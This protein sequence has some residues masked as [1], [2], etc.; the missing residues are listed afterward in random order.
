MTQSVRRAWIRDLFAVLLLGG[1]CLLFF[2]AIITP[3]VAD[4]GSFPPGD[5][6][7]QFH[8]FAVFEAHELL[9]GHIPLW[10]P[11][12]YS[13]HPFE[14]DIQAAI[15]YPVSLLTILL[16]W[17]VSVRDLSFLA[18][19]WEAILHFWL[20]AV[21]TYFFARRLLHH[22]GA[23]L[24]SAIVFAFGGYLTS[25]PSQ[26]LAVLETATWLPLVLWL[27]D[28]GMGRLG[29]AHESSAPNR[30]FA[31]RDLWPMV[32]AGLAWGFALLAGHP[33]TAMYIFYTILLYM[34]FSAWYYHV[35][36][37]RAL[38]GFV[39]LQVL[40][41]ALAAVQLIPGLE[42]MRLSVRA[43]IGYDEV[44]GGFARQDILQ[45]LLPGSSGV[46]SPLYVGV[47]PLLLAILAPILRRTAQVVFWSATAIVAL[48]LSFGG[49][50]FFYS[51]FYLAV[52]GF[53]LFRSQERSAFIFSFALAILA[54]FGVRYLLAPLGRP[55]KRKFNGFVSA[56]GYL[57]LGALLL[58]ALSYYGWL[59]D[60]WSPESPY[61]AGLTRSVLLTV[62]LALTWFVLWLRRERR[63]RSTLWLVLVLA[64]V[65]FDL[66]TINWQNN[67]SDLK[68]EDHWTYSPL[69]LVPMQD[70][71]RP[72]RVHNEWRLPPNYGCVYQL[73]D[74]WGASPLRIA[75]YDE[76]L[77]AVPLERAWELLNVRYVI[78]W[79]K[80]LPVKS[81]LLYDEPSGDE[82]AYLHRLDQVG[83]RAYV[84]HAARVVS[85]TAALT[86]LAD[87]AFD[88]FAEA[89]LAE[90]L[91]LPLDTRPV[92]GTT[93]IEWTERSADALAL[94]VDTPASGLLVLSEVDYPG[95]EATVDGTPTEVHR[96][97]STLRAV[98]LTA[99]RH[100]VEMRFRPRSFAI[101]AVVSL[102]AL[103]LTAAYLVWAA[104][105]RSHR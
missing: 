32:L 78:T 13:G 66:F 52:P 34:I 58:V 71:D 90:P 85:D 20:A 101:G 43:T 31:L 88:P 33:Q 67:L 42:Y 102:T 11:F 27:V 72:F 62:L 76:F 50:T 70:E 77:S 15:F 35:T 80:T 2:W 18:L 10:C 16:S 81:D 105:S 40:G 41:F 5:F 89:L 96:A 56:T 9:A 48:L 53:G 21:F 63:A 24:L 22:R 104:L 4:K 47:L 12:V 84:V 103:L 37:K 86:L 69:E 26:Q 30:P 28:I 79:R 7:D 8:A 38:L 36:W 17:L 60:G 87:P 6:G 68:P 45:L 44:A 51:L 100:H 1:L 29:S 91:A 75:A 93:T 3:N 55:L 23:A 99:G 59:V 14:A 94:D 83:P 82:T 19:E 61:A 54:G 95:W 25:Y 65:T 92:T 98:P 49:N 73:E 46:M 57:T 97:Q 74:I 64:L 39:L